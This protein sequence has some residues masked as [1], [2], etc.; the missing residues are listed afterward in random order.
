MS[1]GE[2]MDFSYRVMATYKCPI[3]YQPLALAFHQDRPDDESLFKQAYGYGAGLAMMYGRHP[4]ALPW[5]ATQ[6]L[7]RAR[8]T[9]RRRVG[10][11]RAP[12]AERLG[13]ATPQEAEFARYLNLWN[14]AYWRGFD[15]ELRKARGGR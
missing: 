7:R 9:V 15:D 12:L 8:T 1:R 10:A 3:E 4:D 14:Q 13:K 2:D 11:V 6:R 5:G